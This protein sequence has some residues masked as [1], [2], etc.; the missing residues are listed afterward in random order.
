MRA[1]ITVLRYR[2]AGRKPA[3]RR[4]PEN[5]RR[6]AA[7]P[8]GLALAVS[9]LGPAGA[10]A[11]TPDVVIQAGAADPQNAQAPFQY[12]RFYPS[13][14][15][16][17]RGALIEWQPQGIFFSFHTVTFLGGQ[18]PPNV[19][20]TDE[21]AP[22]IGFD[23]AWLFGTGCGDVPRDEP[24]CVVTGPDAAFS[25]DQM[26]FNPT[27]KRM[28]RT[29]FRARIAPD[30]PL[31]SYEYV[32]KFHPRMTATLDVVADDEAVPGVDDVR[33][34][35]RAEIDADTAAA[36]ALV[37]ARSTTLIPPYRD[38]DGVRVRTAS[39]GAMTADGHVTVL[40][41]FPPTLNVGSGERVRFVTEGDEAHTVTFPA[42]QAG[43]FNGPQ[44]TPRGLGG[45]QLLP[46]CE[47]DDPATGM[48]AMPLSYVA[49]VQGCPPG[50]Q[51]EILWAPW[52]AEGTRAPGD[53]IATEAT[54]H[55][56]GTMIPADTP[57][58]FRARPDRMED[59]PATFIAN[60]S[61]LGTF[62]YACNVHA[63]VMFGALNVV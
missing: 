55:N 57:A 15:R 19:W 42:E 28:T 47:L 27:W 61:N 62:D 31:G 56:S 51:P 1:M 35:A 39:V 45:N 43:D 49:F 10:R 2:R 20:R 4:E 5:M 32:C 40:G 13:S 38:P 59:F 52:M 14:V 30:A 6:I 8:I 36:R 24:P 25:S 48:P 44:G 22:A 18:A 12:T 41:F 29:P 9:F 17:H 21:L 33:A 11:A 53:E 54:F 58:W 50:T 46:G 23:E 60:V 7:L 37:T 3:P 63:G 16:V 26:W 34:Q